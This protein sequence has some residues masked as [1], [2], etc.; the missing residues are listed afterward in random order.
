MTCTLV[1]ITYAVVTCR[2]ESECCGNQSNRFHTL[3]LA[4]SRE[5]YCIYL[6]TDQ[7][8]RIVKSTGARFKDVSGINIAHRPYQRTR[9]QSYYSGIGKSCMIA[10]LKCSLMQ[11][12]AVGNHVKNYEVLCWIQDKEYRRRLDEFDTRLQL[13]LLSSNCKNCAQF[14]PIIQVKYSPIQALD[15][16]EEKY[17]CFMRTVKFLNELEIITVSNEIDICCSESLCLE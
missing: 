17:V 5:S 10:Q 6:L 2:L 8:D 15:F 1:K 9:S 4:F 3:G 16:P 13:L 7:L 14:I 11:G 12:Q